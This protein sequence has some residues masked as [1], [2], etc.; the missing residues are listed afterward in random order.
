VAQVLASL[1]VEQQK[2]EEA[3]QHLRKSM[4]KWFPSLQRMLADSDSDKDE[5]EEENDMEEDDENLDAQL[6]SFEFRFETAKLLIE[7]DETTEKAVLVSSFVSHWC[8]QLH[9]PL[10]EIAVLAISPVPTLL[11]IAPLLKLACPYAAMS[12]S[13][14]A[15]SS[16]Q[17]HCALPSCAGSQKRC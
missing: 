12:G 9:L 2:P 3:L 14:I 10:V 17:G 6:P 1:K 7:L 13:L 16:A 5:E 15:M 8:P 4:Q 11:V